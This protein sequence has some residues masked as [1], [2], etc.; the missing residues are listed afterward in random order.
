[1]ATRVLIAGISARGFAESAARA[2]YEVTA[3]DGFG[4]LDLEA[5]A[6]R[7]I[8]L[9]Q[10][11]DGDFRFRARAAVRSARGIACDA[12]AY[13]AGFENH[14][15]SV[16][17]LATARVLWGN[18]PAVLARVRDP[19]RLARAL[20]K[21]GCATPEVR[22]ARA[23][24]ASPTRWLLKPRASG[25]GH[26]IRSWRY[27][28]GRRV[29]SE[30]YLQERMAGVAGSI[31]FAADGVRAVP[32][33]MSRSLAGKRVFGA[34][35]FQYCGSILAGADDAQFA[36]DARLCAAAT[37]L[38]AAVTKEFG[39][40]GVNGIDFIARRGVPYAI[41]VNPR[42]TASME[43][44]ERTYGL[45]MFDIHA[46]AC[47][48]ALPTFDLAGARAAPGAIGKA[49][50][51]ARRTVTLDDTTSWLADGSVRDV[52]RPRERIAR[53]RPVCT[54]FARG[55]DGADCYAALGARAAAL[56]RTIEP[57]VLRI[58]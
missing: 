6:H 47:A 10:A 34:R 39:L 8:A 57:R 2:G 12:V 49:I 7:T 33:G 41:E 18:P 9:R 31:V 17:A 46:R 42:Y 13:V 36:A 14:P 20:H 50:V 21:R 38:A 52:P 55:R 1:M 43:L 35:G 53:G 56:Y 44:V 25:G 24:P 16:A 5:R 26:G 58:A 11:G 54:I 3:V 51:Y 15:R 4:D 37:V 22:V 30:M 19:L 48:G 27:E 29:P 45:S 32:L 40:V 23:S 28:G